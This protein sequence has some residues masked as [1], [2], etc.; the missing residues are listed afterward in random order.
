MNRKNLVFPLFIAII[1]FAAAACGNNEDDDQGKGTTNETA[2]SISDDYEYEL[3]VIFHV[4]Y[5][6]KND[7]LQYPRQSRLNLIID[8]VNA[9]YKR[10]GMN[11]TFKMAIADE[12]GKTLGE[13][14]VLRHEVSFDDYNYKDFLYKSSAYGEE[15]DSLSYSP[16]NS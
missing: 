6:D 2:A 4:L 16:E 13:P 9:L 14:G 5:K 1:T 12:N 15:W 8:S 10:N 3:P 7:A 11:V